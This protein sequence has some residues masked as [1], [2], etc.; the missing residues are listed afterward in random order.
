MGPDRHLAE[1]SLPIQPSLSSVRDV[2]AFG[3]GDGAVQASA[4]AEFARPVDNFH[5]WASSLFRKGE[6]PA[7][8]GAQQYIPG[9]TRVALSYP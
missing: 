7:L 8:A 1:A 6:A 4:G 3:T 5:G 9:P 2:A